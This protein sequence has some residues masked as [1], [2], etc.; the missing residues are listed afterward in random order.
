MN[1][2][3]YT[4]IDVKRLRAYQVNFLK[5]DLVYDKGCSIAGNFIPHQIDL[6]R[7]YAL[8]AEEFSIP[9]RLYPRHCSCLDLTKS[10]QA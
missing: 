8:I 4:K 9:D 7:Q 6:L 1:N 2:H 3:V 5:Q 10:D